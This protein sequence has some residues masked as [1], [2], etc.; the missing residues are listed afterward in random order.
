MPV[1]FIIKYFQLVVLHID[2]G[3][4]GHGNYPAS[5]MPVDGPECMYLLEVNIIEPCSF[6]Q[7]PV[8]R[9]MDIFVSSYQVA[10]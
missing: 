3:T 8:S 7:Y 2:Q 10:Q 6:F 4:V 5:R 9:V 1:K